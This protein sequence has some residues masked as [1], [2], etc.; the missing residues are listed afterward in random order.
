M[1]R[2]P[3]CPH[4]SGGPSISHSMVSFRSFYFAIVL[5]LI[6]VHCRVYT[7]HQKLGADD[8]DLDCQCRRHEQHSINSGHGVFLVRY[9]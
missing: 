2:P 3:P 8:D 1:Y 5:S 9:L 4:G 6:L 7:Y